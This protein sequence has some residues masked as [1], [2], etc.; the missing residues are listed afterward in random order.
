L[1]KDLFNGI[2]CFRT[3]ATCIPPGRR[4]FR[5]AR[6]IDLPC[7]HEVAFVEHE[8]SGNFSGFLNH[9]LIQRESVIERLIPRAVYY[10]QVTRHAAKVGHTNF[11]VHVFAVNVPQ[12]QSD[13]FVVNANDFLINFYTDGRVI[14]LGKNTFYKT[15]DQAGFPNGERA[16][17]AD[18]LL[19][20]SSA[21]SVSGSH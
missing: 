8:N 15:A 7:I 5:F 13:I 12:N 20:H 10:E 21:R 17:H 9:A 1:G 4:Q 11:L 3:G 2:A 6:G 19:Q 16:E 14:S 18:F